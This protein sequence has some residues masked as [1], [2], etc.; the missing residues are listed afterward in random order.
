MIVRPRPS[1]LRLF[2]VMQGS[3]IPRILPQILFVLCVS[4][5]VVWA[6]HDIPAIVPGSLGAPFAL[7]GIAISIFL[8]FRNSACY[9]RWWEA[10]KNWGQIIYA[11]RSFGRQAEILP[12]MH[13][14][15]GKAARR[16]LSELIIALPHVLVTYL[17]P[18]DR[19][20]AKLTFLPED[21]RRS[22]DTANNPPDM[23]LRR[24]AQK[25]A[26]LRARDRLTD[27]QWQALDNSVQAM[28]IAI[29]N[30]ERLRFTPLPFAYTLLVH[31][32]AHLFCFLLPFGFSDLLGWGTPLVA[33]LIAY[34]FFGL[35][36]LGDELEEPFGT[37]P[38]DLAI[39]ALAAV[40]ERDMRESLGETNLPP[41]PQPVNYVLT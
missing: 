39:G 36:A 29:A 40:I 5:L 18:A 8:G 27:I 26:E 21:L 38:N 15:E 35:D 17:R 22:L 12:A 37:G 9:D 2:F 10:R 6:H 20:E 33:A 41:L 32:T 28:G 30:C 3:I 19:S 25:L 7:L 23:I 24:I 4:A 34:T 13:G 11:A 31:R 1:L 16:Q 14:E